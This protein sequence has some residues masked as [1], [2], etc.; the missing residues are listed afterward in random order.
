MAC[1]GGVTSG[2]SACRMVG[3]TL[4]EMVCQ[5]EK[6]VG[7]WSSDDGLISMWATYVSNELDVQ[8][9]LAKSQ[10]KHVEEKFVDRKIEVQSGLDELRLIM[11]SL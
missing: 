11:E 8:R 7:D 6:M 10:A 9:D 1:F 4:K 2:I 5:L 3:E